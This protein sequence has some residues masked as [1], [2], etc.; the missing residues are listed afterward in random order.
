MIDFAQDQQEAPK[1]SPQ[2][3]YRYEGI[4]KV[5]GKAKYAAEFDGPFAKADLAYAYIVQ[6]TIASGSVKSMD[7]TAASKAPGVLAIIT[8]FNAPKLNQGPPKPPARRSL[9][10]M[11]NTDVAY[12]GQPIAVVIAKTLVEAKAA[13]AMVKTTYAVQPAKLQWEK[14]LGEARWPKNPGKD[15]ATNHRGDINAAFAKAAVTLDNTYVTPIQYHN[16]M[17]PHATIAWWQG[18]KVTV[19][20]ATQY[21]SGVKMSL[22]RTL[23]V[24]IDYVHVMDP[25]VGGGFGSKGSMWSH[26][27][28]CAMASKLTNRPVKL[29]LEREQMFGLV[30]SRPSTINHIRLAATQDGTL[31]GMQHD[32]V[33]N[34]SVLEDFVEHTEDVTRSLYQSE[35][36]SVTAKVVEANLGVSTFMRAPGESSGTAVLEIAMDEMAEKL[37]MDPVE[38]RLKNYAETDPSNEHR[39]WSSKH[40]RECYAQGAQKFGWSS[41][42]TTPGGRSEGEWLIGHGMATATYPANR[43]AA[44]AVVRLLPGGKMFVG[45]GTQDLGTGTYTIMAQQAAAGLGLDPRNVEVQLGDSTLPK[46]PVSGGSQSAASVLPAIQ[47]ANTQLKLKLVDLAINDARSPMHGLQAA[48]CDVKDGKLIS[49]SQPGKTDA[50]TDLIARNNNQP[51]EAQ[52]QAEPGESHDAMTTHSWGAVFAEVAVHR[53]T[54]MTKTRRI[55]AV[56]DIG[57]LLNQKTGLNQLMGG[58]TWGIGFAT[59]EH[60]VIDPVTGRVVNANLAEYHVPVNADVGVMDVSVVGIPDTKFA[61]T[62]ARGIGEIGVTGAAAA[63]ANAIY[64]ATGKRVREYPISPDKLLLG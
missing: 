12:N 55:V 43:S 57:V 50:L 2:L 24:P 59:E 22:A 29:V 38:F 15:P 34:A 3:D 47:D 30:G 63:V 53:Y 62:G 40:L 33:M 48:D 35:T 7:I 14:R 20:D 4:D 31:L 9:T 45:S 39:P 5:T 64:N 18:D 37:K 51:V 8:P 16:P 36:N 26:V 60:G 49:K 27:P 56:Y 21:I 19:Y 61:P 10:L 54:G 23:S 13:A 44:Q 1:P 41:R 58:L 52:G 11:Q 6:A 25:V 32:N 46:A 28:L 42:N 17:E